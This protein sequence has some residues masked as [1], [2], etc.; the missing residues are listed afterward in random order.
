MAEKIVDKVIAKGILK[1]KS[2]DEGDLE[3]K[4]N[5]VLDDLEELYREKIS[6][7]IFQELEVKEG[8][9][10][11]IV[12]KTK[13]LSKKEYKNQSENNE[14]WLDQINKPKPRSIGFLYVDGLQDEPQFVGDLPFDFS[15]DEMN[16]LVLLSK[17]AET[18]LKVNVFHDIEPIDQD[19]FDAHL[20]MHEHNKMN[21]SLSDE[22][23]AD[24]MRESMANE[25]EESWTCGLCEV[26]QEEGTPFYITQYG[27]ACLSCFE[28]FMGINE[29]EE[30]EEDLEVEEDD[31]NVEKENKKSTKL[32]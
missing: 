6:E 2:E 23:R 14:Q 5:F 31:D 25:S 13:K 3:I 27:T 11:E 28:S 32:N 4:Q 9:E 26:E 24:Y 20:Y 10:F 1:R 16:E 7:V 29:E 30:E 12:L 22:E 17:E 15:Q 21:R 19:E 8:Y 18:P